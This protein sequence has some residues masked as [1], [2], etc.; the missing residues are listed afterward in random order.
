VTSKTAPVSLQSAKGKVVLWN[1]K[2]LVGVF[3]GFTY[4]F[5]VQEFVP[6]MNGIGSEIEIQL[7]KLTT[8][9]YAKFSQQLAIRGSSPAEI[10]DLRCTQIGKQPGCY[11]VRNHGFAFA[12]R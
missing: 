12:M 11:V 2:L 4:L 6:S 7:T 8:L 3:S 5:K 9:S 1:S 10:L